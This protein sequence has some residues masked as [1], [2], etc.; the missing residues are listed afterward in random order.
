MKRWFAAAATLALGTAAQPARAQFSAAALY[1][2]GAA[3]ADVGEDEGHPRFA[4]GLGLCGSYSLYPERTLGFA[5]GADVLV[6]GFGIDIPGRV[7]SGAGVF[8]QTDLVID[9]W[10]AL[11]ISRILAGIYFEQ[12]RIDRGTSLGVIGSPASAIGV[13]LEP[14]FTAS[15]RTRARVSYARYS[16]GSLRLAGSDSEPALESGWSLR[17]W[18]RHQLTSRWGVQAEY[19]D[20]KL[21]LEEVAPTLGFFDHRQSTLSVGAVVSF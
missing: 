14:W 19:S 5:A 11:R 15:G 12:R 18:L 6:R 3:R 1:E 17:A 2:L 9:E 16:G 4:Y 10:L 13:L 7:Q 21:E 8:D 20:V